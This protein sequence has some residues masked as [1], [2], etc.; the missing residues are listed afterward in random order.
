MKGKK[1]EIV[2]V[3]QAYQ[4]RTDVGELRDITTLEL[5]CDTA[6]QA[7]DRAKKLI[8]KKFYRVSAIIEKDYDTAK[9]CTNMA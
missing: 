7:L 9:C 3:V 1:R 4:E 8:K 2:F 5:F 6:D